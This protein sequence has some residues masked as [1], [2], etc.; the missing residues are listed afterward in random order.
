PDVAVRHRPRLD[1]P[2]VRE[3]LFGGQIRIDR[4]LAR[5]VA[6]EPARLETAV[7]TVDAEHRRRAARRTQQVENEP[8]R[9]RLAGAVGAEEAEDLAALDVERETIH[10]DHSTEVL[11][12]AI[13]VKGRG[14]DRPCLS[15]A[16][17]RS[18]ATKTSVGG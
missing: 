5:Q 13:E 6:D 9:R 3:V 17:S 14:H 11:G 15:R 7:M 2:E 10:P 16:S 8:D 12:E 1:R 18:A 4:Q